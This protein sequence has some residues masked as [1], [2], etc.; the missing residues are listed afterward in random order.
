MSLKDF[1]KQI[2]VE[3][4]RQ[5]APDIINMPDDLVEYL[6]KPSSDNVYA[7]TEPVLLDY[8]YLIV[9]TEA[10]AIQIFNAFNDVT[11]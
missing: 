3:F 7:L 11:K 6:S 8:V 5:T 10:K 4:E 9:D 1:L 2:A